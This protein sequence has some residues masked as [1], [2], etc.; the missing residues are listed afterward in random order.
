M[1]NRQ[2]KDSNRVWDLFSLNYA[3]KSPSR[4]AYYILC[5]RHRRLCATGTNASSLHSTYFDSRA[6]TPRRRRRS[7]VTFRYSIARGWT[8]DAK[9]T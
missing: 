9:L 3:A 7:R 2:I 5:I 1:A 4:C 6:T 8:L